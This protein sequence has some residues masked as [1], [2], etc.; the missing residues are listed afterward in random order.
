MWSNGTIR[1]RGPESPQQHS[2]LTIPWVYRYKCVA[3]KKILL[4]NSVIVF[5]ERNKG[6]LSRSEFTILT[7]LTG[8]EALQVHRHERA[9]LII[10]ELDM[11][12][13]KGDELCTHLRREK[14]LRNVS[15]LLAC[16]DTPENRARVALCGANSWLP[17]PI[18]PE[19]L[20]ESV[21]QLLAVSAR[22]GYRVLL[23][24]HVN[25]EQELSP[26]FCTS[27]NISSTGILFETDKLLYKGDRITCE[28]FLPGASQVTAD[29]EIV[30]SVSMPDGS[31]HYGVRF[32]DLAPVFRGKIEKFVATFNLTP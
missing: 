1:E 25:G 32:I 20:L 2:L 22:Q 26:F 7:A 4:V 16:V 31:F 10:A 8:K 29:G 19:R 9:D 23:K 27:R 15:V 5:H 14:D 3:M 21:G 11:P 30:R 17:K 18:D 13:M 28:F 6:L 12:G 24:A